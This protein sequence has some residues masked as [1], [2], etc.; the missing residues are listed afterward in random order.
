MAM[1][2]HNKVSEAMKKL[3]PNITYRT[4][5]PDFIDEATGELWE[6]TTSNPS[7]IASPKAKGGDY[8][9]ATYCTYQLPGC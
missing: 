6:F 8:L 3:Y 1:G 2:N 9:K 5:G 7:T 4:T